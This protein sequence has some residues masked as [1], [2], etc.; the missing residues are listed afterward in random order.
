MK[1]VFIPIESVTVAHVARPLQIAK[2]LRD[3]GVEAIFG[4]GERYRWLIEE[5]G[6]KGAKVGGAMASLQHPNYL[7]NTGNATSADVIAL[8]DKIKR[9]V[10]DKF[11]VE[12]KEEAVVLG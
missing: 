8:A 12:L 10:K 3:R 2:V 5:A 11:N 7:V 6:M 4:M 9:T 1:R